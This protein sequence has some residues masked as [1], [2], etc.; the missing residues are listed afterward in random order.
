MAK[1]PLK[2]NPRAANG[3]LKA[4]YI[5][6][7]RDQLIGLIEYID[8][9]QGEAITFDPENMQECIELIGSQEKNKLEL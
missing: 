7:T 1:K 6:I 9:L 5:T 4:N 2:S 3:I 8:Q